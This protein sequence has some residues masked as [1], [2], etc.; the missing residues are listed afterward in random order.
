M[1]LYGSALFVHVVSAI[2]LVGGGA[3]THVAMTLVPRAGSVD[4]VRAHVLWLH[5]LVKAL[6]PLAVVV[7][8]T[9]L[10]LTFAGSWWGAGW[11][12][13]SLALFALAGAAAGGFIDPRVARLRA[14]LDEAR[15]GPVTSELTGALTDPGLRLAGAILTGADVAIVFLMT[16]KPGWT[17]SLLVALVGVTIG[18]LV[19]LTVTRRDPGRSLDA[20]ADAPPAATA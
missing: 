18:G 3:C 11:P 14:A 10:Y 1:T 13:V 12:V 15:E 7:L 2:L 20:R 17:G 6:T 16:N 4:G 5:V 19:G 9:G 8:A